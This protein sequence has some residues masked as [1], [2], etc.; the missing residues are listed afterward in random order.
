MPPRP[1]TPAGETPVP[2][3]FRWRLGDAC[4]P[5]Q[6]IL[7]DAGYQEVARIDGIDSS[8]CRPD[9]AVGQQ[10]A[11]GGTWHWYVVG[12]C[13]ARPVASPLQTFRIL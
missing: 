13:F 5:F 3:V 8:E 6:W 7:M 9:P 4:P 11:D 10:F 1:I 2:V 12:D